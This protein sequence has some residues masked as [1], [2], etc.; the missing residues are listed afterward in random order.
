MNSIKKFYEELKKIEN[1]SNILYMKIESMKTIFFYDEKSI[2]IPVGY[3]LVHEKFFYSSIPTPNEIEY[4]INYIEDE[5]E[6][7][8]PLLPKKY[9]LYTKEKFILDIAILCNENISDITSLSKDKMEYIFGEYAN[10]SQGAVA[11]SYQKDLSAD[12]YAKLLILREYMHHINFD[13][14]KIYNK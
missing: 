11:S 4:A 10:V 5:I 7:V 3:D 9:L 14:L 12:F 8:V 13:Y 2:E 6:K 1:K